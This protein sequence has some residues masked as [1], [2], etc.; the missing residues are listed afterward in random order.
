MC[1]KKWKKTL[2]VFNKGIQ[3]FCFFLSLF[4]S[5]SMDVKCGAFVPFFKR[6]IIAWA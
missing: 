4:L 1:K 3:L 5:L 2:S 6:E